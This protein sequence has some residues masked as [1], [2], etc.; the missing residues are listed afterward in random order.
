MPIRK[1]YK[2]I[3]NNAR[4]AWDVEHRLIMEKHLGRKLETLESV[5]HIN[6]IRDDN[7]IENLVVMRCGEHV[8]QHWVKRERKKCSECERIHHAK[9]LCNTHYMRG[10]RQHAG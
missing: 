10:F 2:R 1:G 7:R 8:K 3:W 5:H 6:G 9:G 4:R